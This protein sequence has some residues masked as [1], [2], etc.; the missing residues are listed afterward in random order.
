M[1][2]I[3]LTLAAVLLFA[4][5]LSVGFNTTLGDFLKTKT[6]N[7]IICVIVIGLGIFL[8]IMGLQEI[9]RLSKAYLE[10]NDRIISPIACTAI[11]GLL[12]ASGALVWYYKVKDMKNKPKKR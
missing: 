1:L 10:I 8:F 3:V 12:A 4:I 9:I 5:I 2:D 6:A 11:G 7:T